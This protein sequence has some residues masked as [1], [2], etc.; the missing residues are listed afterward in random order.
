MAMT[1]SEIDHPLLDGI[2]LA[3]FTITPVATQRDVSDGT[4]IATAG[5]RPVIVAYASGARRVVEWRFDVLNGSVTLSPAF[6]LLVANAIEWLTPNQRNVTTSTATESDL[7][8]TRVA[9]LPAVLDAR[10]GTDE[11]FETTALLLILALGALVMEWRH[12][13]AAVRQ[14]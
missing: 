3:D 5:D 2:G 6:P 14:I 7:R 4:V 12:R 11:G 13:R 1:P 8:A 9:S 10:P